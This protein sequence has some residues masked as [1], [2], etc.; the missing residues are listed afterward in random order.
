MLIKLD[1]TKEQIE[2][3]KPIEVAVK[4]D[5]A[6]RDSWQDLWDY[7][8]RMVRVAYNGGVVD[9]VLLERP[10]SNGGTLGLKFE[11]IRLEVIE[12]WGGSDGRLCS[13][14]VK[15]REMAYQGFAMQ[16]WKFFE[17]QAPNIPFQP[18]S[19]KAAEVALQ[20]VLSK[21]NA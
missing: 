6:R 3:G 16:G 8:N 1:L 2:A 7:G 5:K 21:I 19:P 11:P 15:F 10:L 13:M 4:R 20:F 14:F 17:T 12:V 9:A 18:A